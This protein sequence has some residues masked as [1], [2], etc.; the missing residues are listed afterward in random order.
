MLHP[1][2]SLRVTVF[3]SHD[4]A[5]P[6]RNIIGIPKDTDS[7]RA[8][9]K[10]V[11]EVL[12]KAPYELICTS[13]EAEYIKVAGN[14]FLFLKVIYANLMF[15]ASKAQGCDWEIIRQAL[16]ADSRIGPSHLGVLHASGHPGAK[17]GR[18]A[19]GHC[20]VKDFAALRMQYEKVFPEDKAGAAVFKALECKNINLLMESEK[21]IDLLKGVYG[22]D[23]RSTCAS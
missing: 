15:D 3:A 23:P 16:S 22:D 17:P 14:A 10:K 9:A 11:L 6:E 12:P 18:G 4:A 1:C 19:G 8:A 21:D 20:L 7:H 2:L 13:R 5:N